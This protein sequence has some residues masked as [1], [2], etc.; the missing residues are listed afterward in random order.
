MATKA[1]I[2]EKLGAAG[3]PHD[4]SAPVATLRDLLHPEDKPATIEE[5]PAPQVDDARKARWD[6][7]LATAEE[8]RKK[9][10]TIHIF[11]AQKERGEFDVIPDNFA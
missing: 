7:F 10:G 11:L 9:E 2:I 4:P 6:A 5:T 3:I 1:E 8:Q